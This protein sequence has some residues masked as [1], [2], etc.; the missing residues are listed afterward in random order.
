MNWKKNID[1][2][3]SS[4]SRTHRKEE[5]EWRQLLL[6]QKLRRKKRLQLERKVNSRKNF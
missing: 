3:G 5:D 1:Q 4:P 6:Q 2:A